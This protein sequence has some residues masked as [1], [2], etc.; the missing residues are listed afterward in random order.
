[1]KTYM[2]D[3]RD[4][5]LW[6]GQFVHLVCLTV[7]LFI[8]GYGW[9]VLDRPHPVLFWLAVSV[10]I[11]HQIYVWIAWRLELK[12]AFVSNYFGFRFFLIVFFALFLG[13]FLSLVLLGMR[14]IALSDILG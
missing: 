14:Y 1:M 12:Y 9:T 3:M 4:I 11:V 5:D 2:R 10:P 6:K 8:A 13:R 7:L